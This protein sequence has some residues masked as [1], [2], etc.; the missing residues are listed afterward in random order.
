M[1]H[2][3]SEGGSLNHSNF[4]FQATSV[5]SMRTCWNLVWE[6]ISPAAQLLP[7]SLLSLHDAIWQQLEMAVSLQKR[8][9]QKRGLNK[10]HL[11]FNTISLSWKPRNLKSVNCLPLLFHPPRT[12]LRRL[13]NYSRDFLRTR[14]S[15]D[16]LGSLLRRSSYGNFIIE[17]FCS[18]L[19]Q[20]QIKG[21]IAQRQHRLQLK[22]DNNKQTLPSDLICSHSSVITFFEGW[23]EIHGNACR[24]RTWFCS[25]SQSCALQSLY[26]ISKD[27]WQLLLT[28]HECH[29]HSS[30]ERPTQHSQAALRHQCIASRLS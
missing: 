7:P 17:L 4:G 29:P 1:I 15:W 14:Y 18:A 23:F 20:L 6:V 2:I 22:T 30:G 13:P 9:K 16:F 19:N 25:C 12:I 5:F 21:Q 3:C 28:S 11:H 10:S 24:P 27:A 8:F 26:Y